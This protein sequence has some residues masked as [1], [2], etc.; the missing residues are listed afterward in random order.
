MNSGLVY[1]IGWLSIVC[2]LC[3]EHSSW[4]NPELYHVL[5]TVGFIVHFKDCYYQGSKTCNIETKSDILKESDFQMSFDMLLA[6][7]D[8]QTTFNWLLKNPDA[9]LGYEFLE[10]LDLLKLIK[11][12]DELDSASFD[13]LDSVSSDSSDDISW[14]ESSHAAKIVEYWDGST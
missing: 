3:D 11:S 4:Y 6:D 7:P 10:F 8:S 2:V 13:E 14:G 12:S 5:K 1:F 9:W